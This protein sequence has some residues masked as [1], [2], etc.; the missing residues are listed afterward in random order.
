MDNDFGGRSYIPEYQVSPEDRTLG[1]VAHLSAIVT[2]FLGPLIIW[3][4][5]KDQSPFVAKCALEATVFSSLLLVVMILI[6]VVTCGFGVIIVIPLSLAGIFYLVVAGIRANEG[7]VYEYPL[8]TK[9]I[10]TK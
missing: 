7:K 10:S 2:S 3:I 5:K 1:L 4:I 8:T 9:L 6:S